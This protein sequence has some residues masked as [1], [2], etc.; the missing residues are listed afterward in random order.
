M[1]WG[2]CIDW[3]EDAGDFRNN[4]RVLYLDLKLV[5][6]YMDL[7]IWKNSANCILKIYIC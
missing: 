6:C 1:R 2:G 4:G 7:C 3:K 5:G